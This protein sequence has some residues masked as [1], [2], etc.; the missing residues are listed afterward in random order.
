MGATLVVLSMFHDLRFLFGQTGSGEADFPPV[1]SNGGI[2]MTLYTQDMKPPKVGEKIVD[3]NDRLLGRV[4]QVKRV[5]R[6]WK[7]T[8]R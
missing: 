7:V 5:G 2:S 8:V 3:F 1:D 6:R 4:K